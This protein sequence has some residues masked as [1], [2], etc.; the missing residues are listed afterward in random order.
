MDGRASFR[1]GS[2]HLIYC[3]LTRGNG[4]FKLVRFPTNGEGTRSSFYFSAI[5]LTVTLALAKIIYVASAQ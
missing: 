4:L 5:V 1:S 3:R 2:S